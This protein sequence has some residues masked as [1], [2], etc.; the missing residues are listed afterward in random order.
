[1]LLFKLFVE[2]DNVGKAINALTEGGITGFFLHECKGI[3]P[4]KFKVILENLD[5]V[6]EAIRELNDA[7]IIKTVIDK[8]KAKILE[9]IIE[10]KLANERYT[11]IKIPINKIKI[12]TCKKR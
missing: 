11:I 5:E 4:K 9:D 2:K 10:E 6:V 3:S 8:K 12:N 7:I 1:M